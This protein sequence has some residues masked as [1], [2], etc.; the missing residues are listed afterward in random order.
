M[1]LGTDYPY[2]LGEFTSESMGKDYA[3]GHLIDS[4]TWPDP[5]TRA[6]LLVSGAVGVG[7]RTF[8]SDWM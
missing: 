4:M 5:D 2:P 1:C 6:K 8:P 3:P 7:I